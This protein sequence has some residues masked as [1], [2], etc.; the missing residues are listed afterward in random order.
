MV[1]VP[2]SLE[3]KILQTINFQKAISMI[4]NTLWISP[5]DMSITI[6]MAFP[7]QLQ[8]PKIHP[9][10]FSL[11]IK[12][13]KVGAS[14]GKFRYVRNPVPMGNHKKVEAFKGKCTCLHTVMEAMLWYLKFNFLS[15]SGT[16]W[17]K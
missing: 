10:F 5:T 3:W 7:S 12:V 2:T 13:I 17:I 8:K 11:E 9:P 16:E 15:V 14:G 4:K 6:K 1:Y